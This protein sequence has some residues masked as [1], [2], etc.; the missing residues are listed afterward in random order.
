M[1]RFSPCRERRFG[2]LIRSPIESAR[3]GTLLI[4]RRKA[5]GVARS[6]LWCFRPTPERAAFTKHAG[7]RRSLS[8][9]AENEEKRRRS[10]IA[11]EA[12]RGLK[13]IDGRQ[14]P[15]AITGV[16]YFDNGSREAAR[17]TNPPR[18]GR[19]PKERIARRG[20]VRPRQ[21]GALFDRRSITQIEPFGL[22]CRRTAKTSPPPGRSAREGGGCRCC[23][24]GGKLEMRPDRCPRVVLD[25]ANTCRRWSRR[26]ETGAS[27][28][29]RGR[30]GKG[31]RTACASQ[32]V[33]NGRCLDG[34]GRRSAGMTPTTAAAPARFLRQ[35]G[36]HVVRSIAILADGTGPAS[37]RCR[38]IFGEDVEPERYRGSCARCAI[39][40][41]A[42]GRRD[43]RT[44]TEVLRRVAATTSNDRSQITWGPATTWRIFVG[45]EDARLLH[46][47][48]ADL[49][50]RPPHR[51]LGICPF[52]TFSRRWD[53]TQHIV[54]LGRCGRAGRPHDASSAGADIAMYRPIVD[55]LRSRRAGAILLTEFAGEDA[56]DNLRACGARR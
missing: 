27:G 13:A 17:L 10:T 37:P 8:D 39:C 52:P 3:R 18:A 46:R 40:T 11:E 12:A 24:R 45:S 21:P 53:A 44:R 16:S 38:E 6:N 41:G 50:P 32:N 47:D 55:S 30:H 43:R 34:I 19:Q 23:R 14:T 2:L 33:V 15:P 20:P 28:A 35:H 7:F 9:G 54:K 4:E 49:Q 31:Q 48:R 51:V 22:A 42:E 25:A 56:D 26:Y 36:P 1:S 29:A 5:S